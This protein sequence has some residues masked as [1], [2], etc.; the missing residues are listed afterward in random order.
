MAD[1]EVRFNLVEGALVSPAVIRADESATFLDAAWRALG[2]SDEETLAHPLYIRLEDRAGGIR[3][4]DELVEVPA[5]LTI[6]DF[7]AFVD[8]STFR[9]DH[10]GFGG[11]ANWF[12]TVA[13]VR[14]LLDAGL[15]LQGAY[16]LLKDTV[17]DLR[18]LRYRTHARLA[19]DWRDAGENDDVPV[20]LLTLVKAQNPWWRGHFDFVFGLG[21][22]AGSSLLRAAGYRKVRNQGRDSVWQDES[23]PQNSSFFDQ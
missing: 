6:S 13:T 7:V 3:G 21:D 18:K 8:G 2:V 17:G 10:G 23:E 12:E 14:E 19:A 11:D 16:I 20:E 4:V 9:L 15:T 5:D 1:V 22:S